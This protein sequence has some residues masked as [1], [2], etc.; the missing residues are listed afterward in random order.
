MNYSKKI[1][2]AVA[3]E[4]AAKRYEWDSLKKQR[5]K[6]VYS[7]CPEIKE[8]DIALSDVG[9]KIA[10]ATLMGKVGLSERIES[11]KNDNLKLQKRRGELL[12]SLGFDEG[13]TDPPHSCEKC[14]DTGYVGV[15][16]CSC[17]R[18]ALIKKAYECSGLGN[19]LFSQSF[20]NFSLDSLEGEDRE[21]MEQYY[22]SLVKY[23][24]EFSVKTAA[25]LLMVGGTG[26]GKTHLSSAVA[27]RII[28]RGFDVVYENAQNIFFDFE[29]DRFS[30][31]FNGEE[32][33]SFKYL[34]C[35]LLI[36]DDLGSEMISSF[37]VSCLYNLINSRL[38]KGLPIIVSTNFT[39]EAL[40][41]KYD[42]RITSRLF[43]EFTILLFTG[44]D[45]RRKK[46]SKK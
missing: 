18:E 28:D 13:Y 11:I 4:F 37:S 33:V 16:L 20:E 38:N 26:L 36:I 5:L 24:D 21:R 29:R 22:S 6:E 34:D 46:L 45:Q 2:E 42:D 35:D 15:K 43:G 32:P 25:S 12:C 41:K 30:D 14:A 31:R 3:E 19:L 8:I 9:L 10:R 27:K 1:T 40:R 44:K 17:Y 7:L 39:S 23:A